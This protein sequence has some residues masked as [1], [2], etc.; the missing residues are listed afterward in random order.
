MD[1]SQA[2]GCKSRHTSFASIQNLGH[3]FVKKF[4]H[5]GCKTKQLMPVQRVFHRSARLLTYPLV[6]KPAHYSCF[7]LS[8]EYKRISLVFLLVHAESHCMSLCQKV[9]QLIFFVYVWRNNIS[10]VYH[11]LSGTLLKSKKIKNK[12]KTGQFGQTIIM[13]WWSSD[14]DTTARVLN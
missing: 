9:L 5:T 1:Q 13:A 6:V 10:R 4:C 3:L 8:S 14:H 2:T 12:K 7:F 11:G